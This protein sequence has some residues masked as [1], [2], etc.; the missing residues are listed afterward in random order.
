[1]DCRKPLSK[2]SLVFGQLSAYYQWI[3]SIQSSEPVTAIPSFDLLLALLTEESDLQLAQLADQIF[4]TLAHAAIPEQVLKDWILESVQKA[5]DCTEYGVQADAAVYVRVFWEAKLQILPVELQQVYADRRRKRRCESRAL[6]DAYNTLSPAEMVEVG[7]GKEFVVQ[8]KVYKFIAGSALKALV[9]KVENSVVVE[10]DMEEDATME[11]VNEP[12]KSNVENI[13]PSHN[14][15]IKDCSD[16]VEVIELDSLPQDNATAITI[17]QPAAVKPDIRKKRKTDSAPKARTKKP[18]EDALAPEAQKNK[19]VEQEQKD[20]EKKRKDQEKQDREA[21]KKLKEEE[22]EAAKKAKDVARELREQ[23]READ[24]LE[25]EEK[26]RKDQEKSVEGKPKD[27]KAKKTAAIVK[28][29]VR[30]D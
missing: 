30:F 2:N 25:K 23:Q 19:L 9:H 28:D 26:K 24:K 20:A 12:D 27:K 8:D 6:E 5:S 4:P 11:S 3:E 21:A 7:R 22:R 17:D 10:L 1:M 18:K 15:L 13:M 29:Q 14:S 16:P